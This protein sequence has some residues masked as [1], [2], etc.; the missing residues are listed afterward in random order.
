MGNE[1]N[2]EKIILFQLIKKGNKEAYRLLYDLYYPKLLQIARG[3]IPKKEDAEELVQDVFLKVWKKR[4]TINI[5]TNID[6]YLFRMMRNACLDFLRS[7]K[8]A[9]NI[10]NNV[11]QLEAALN[12]K[13][14]TNDTASMILV[15]ELELQIMKAIELLPEKCKTVFLKSRFEGLKTKEIS[16]ELQISHK[17]VEGHITKAIKHLQ[18]H[19]KELLYFFLFI[20][21]FMQG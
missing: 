4:H 6:G 3:Y 15:K 12:Y 2:I 20:F 11:T 9:L 13:A 7:K 10:N 19:I 5:N 17:T 1:A 14:L 8:N 16:E 18:L 21:I